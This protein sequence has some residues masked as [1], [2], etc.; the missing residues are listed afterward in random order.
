MFLAQHAV[1]PAVALSA[2]LSATAE[3]LGQHHPDGVAPSI[4]SAAAAIVKE[5]DE[6]AVVLQECKFAIERLVAAVENRLSNASY[7]VVGLKDDQQPDV[8]MDDRE[9]GTEFT[10]LLVHAM[11]ERAAVLFSPAADLPPTRA[12]FYFRPPGNDSPPNSPLLNEEEVAELLRLQT[13][14]LTIG[15]LESQKSEESLKR[16]QR[17]QELACRA[18]GMATSLVAVVTDCSHQDTPSRVV[19][20]TLPSDIT[21]LVPQRT[22]LLHRLDN[23]GPST[24]SCLLLRPGSSE[25]SQASVL[26]EVCDG[27][28]HLP[29]VLIDSEQESPSYRS[30]ISRYVSE[31]CKEQSRPVVNTALKK[32][33]KLAFR[34][35]RA[36]R[37]PLFV[38]VLSVDEEWVLESDCSPALFQ[39]LPLSPD[40]AYAFNEDSDFWAVDSAFHRLATRPAARTGVRPFPFLPKLFDS[41]RYATKERAEGIVLLASRTSPDEPLPSPLDEGFS[42]G[43][44][45]AATN[46]QC[47]AA[48]AT[49]HAAV[50]NEPSLAMAVDLEGMLNVSRTRRAQVDLVQICVQRRDLSKVC[51]VFDTFSNK[52]VLDAKG[53]GSMKALLEG[54]NPKVLHCCYG[55]SSSLVQHQIFLNNVFD[56]G[57]ADSLLLCKHHNSP[58]DLG[59]VLYHWLG[60]QAVHLNHKGKLVFVERMF[61]ERPLPSHLFVYAYEDVLFCTLLYDEMAKQLKEQGLL[62]LAFSLSQQRCRPA[63]TPPADLTFLVLLDST[64]MVCL[65]NTSTLQHSLPCGVLAST[66]REDVRCFA[67]DT[68]SA[69]MGPPPKGVAGSVHARLQKT[70]YLNESKLLIARIKSCAVHLDALQASLEFIGKA[71]QFRVVLR[72]VDHPFS[73]AGVEPA[74]AAPAFQFLTAEARRL[75]PR[76][77]PTSA[78]SVSIQV[79]VDYVAHGV[80]CKRI[81]PESLSALGHSANIVTGTVN[82]NFR[83]AVIICNGRDE[84]EQGSFCFFALAKSPSAIDGAVVLQFPSLPIEVGV[85]GLETVTRAI[86]C[87]LGP[88]ARRGGRLPE[89]ADAELHLC[90]LFSRAV[91]RALDDLSYVGS[92]GN[93]LYY[94]CMVPGLADF[95]ASIAASRRKNNGYRVTATQEKL[96]PSCHVRL[97]RSDTVQDAANSDNS[98]VLAPADHEAWKRFLSWQAG[99]ETFTEPPFAQHSEQEGVAAA[100]AW[101]EQHPPSLSSSGTPDFPG[102]IPTDCFSAHLSDLHHPDDQFEI[103]SQGS[104]CETLDGNFEIDRPVGED[105]EVDVLFQAAVLYN[106]ALCTSESAPGSEA[107][108]ALSEAEYSR[109]SRKPDAAGAPP[110]GRI[111]TASEIRDAQECHPATRQFLMALEVPLAERPF[112]MQPVLPVEGESGYHQFLSETRLHFLSEDSLLCRRCPRLHVSSNGEW[113]EFGPLSEGRIVL[114]PKYQN[115]AMSL[116]HDRNG[117][118]GV[119]KTFPSLARK[120]YWGSLKGMRTD[121]SEYIGNC[122]AC[123]HCNVAHHKSGAGT[124]VQFGEGPWEKTTADYF[125]VG[126]ASKKGAK[127]DASV[128]SGAP[129]LDPLAPDDVIIAGDETEDVASFDGTVSFGCLFSRMVKAAAVKGQPTSRTIARIL[130]NEVI[131]HYGTPRSVRSDHGS[132]FVSKVLKALYEHFGIKMEASAPYIHRTV[133]FIERWHSVLKHLVMTHYHSTKDERWHVYLP[134]MELAFN[135]AVNTAVGYSPFFINHFCH[136]RLPMDSLSSIEPAL[137]SER[138][139]PEWFHEHLAVRG[140]VHDAVGQK[141]SLNSLHRLRQFNLARDVNTEHLTPGT[142][143]LITKGAAMD[144]KLPKAEE[145][146]EGPFTIER[147]LP[148]GDLALADVRGRRF[149]NQI[150]PERAIRFPSVRT[151]AQTELSD[152]YPVERIRDRRVSE[153]GSTLEYRL[154]WCG[155]DAS[156]YRTWLSMDFLIDI[157]PLVADYNA[158]YPLPAE[159]APEL[160]ERVSRDAVA[161]PPVESA[162]RERAHFRRSKP[163]DSGPAA[164]EQ[165]EQIPLVTAPSLPPVASTEVEDESSPVAP[166]SDPSPEP[167]STTLLLEGV[168]V[169]VF[170]NDT[171]TPLQLRFAKGLHDVW[172]PATVRRVRIQPSR[173]SQPERRFVIV[174][175]DADPSSKEFGFDIEGTR[176]PVRLSPT[177]AAAVVPSLPPLWVRCAHG[178]VLLRGE[179]T[180]GFSFSHCTR[181]E[182]CDP[183]GEWLEQFASTVTGVRF[184]SGCCEPRILEL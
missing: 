62:E 52:G 23:P 180:C 128:I 25:H 34:S 66:E 173:R 120:Y 40:L 30:A 118:M 1:D 131:R 16:K 28:L 115:W 65:E 29:S 14:D 36:L 70:I 152:W 20:F 97:S 112:A 176:N 161:P 33:K 26:V 174:L 116:F 140:I 138:K 149:K 84:Q 56:T 49:L 143:I 2:A 78:F 38:G 117:H 54:P 90:P 19:P 119:N 130:I 10:A 67:R 123:L 141:L 137:K 96:Y 162:A 155:F 175:F 125:K 6:E 146:N 15:H 21:S 106:F 126:R 71:S 87:W 31:G 100:S 75:R 72:E 142:R 156:A 92:S 170:F 168:K 9:A 151:I 133:G 104:S 37:G 5:R 135:A 122:V 61:Q 76:T 166:S 182:C 82:S 134:F 178:A 58:R 74:F 91:E 127:N 160:H 132:N 80:K 171:R 4:S 44:A 101:A 183:C 39:F 136:P 89:N 157:A 113:F 184:L 95:R 102:V 22:S 121:Y 48:L 109:G 114:P 73:S 159:F 42:D 60:D 24:I 148:N 13:T 99:G 86:D 64:H 51:F 179:G 17:I 164:A 3:K 98:V 150:H 172:L 41:A 108:S 103:V 167:L 50:Q 11:R 83:A 77:N 69:V 111:P 110:K 68:W 43:P 79:V 124:V 12:H 53:P 47:S 163:V 139:L 94:C 18:T 177:A 59:T 169:E 181:S 88:A 144:K 105:P 35:G 32:A 107:F 8:I 147:V 27:E 158:K 45:F 46:A 85:S 63:S 129:N 93:T 145:P 81:A 153:D 55:D 165:P 7:P 57:I 154:E